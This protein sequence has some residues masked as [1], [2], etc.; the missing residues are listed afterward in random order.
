MDRPALIPPSNVLDT[1]RHE[2]HRRPAWAWLV[3]V[4][5]VGVV[6]YLLRFVLLPFV[7]A[8]ALAFLVYPARIWLH[9]RLRVPIVLSAVG[10]FVVLLAAIGGLVAFAGMLILDDA[11]GLSAKAPQTVHKMVRDAIGGEHAEILGRQVDAEQVSRQV[12]DHPREWLGNVVSPFDVAA[13]SAGGIAAFVLFLV[14][15]FYFLLQG[16]RIFA[17]VLW[18]V[19]PRSRPPTVHFCSRYL[20]VLRRYIFG[21]LIIIVMTSVLAWIGTGLFLELPHAVLLSLVTGFLELIPVVGPIAAIVM[22]TLVA[23]TNGGLPAVFAVAALV[24][25]LRLLIDQ[26]IGPLILGKAAQLHP[27]TI[28]FAFLVGGALFGILGVLLAIPVAAAIKLF[29]KDAYTSPETPRQHT[30]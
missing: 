2:E 30:G 19:P 8:A 28:I 15:L 6:V 18:L 5:I 12:L 14:L 17:G 9:Q 3:P 7:G 10:L 1:E 24:I 20:P 4:A 22:L 27:V 21:V 25:V 16:P 26:V 23:A 13:A 11:R 29:L